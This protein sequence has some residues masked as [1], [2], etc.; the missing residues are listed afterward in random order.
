MDGR[1]L[2]GHEHNYD[3]YSVSVSDD[4]GNTWSVEEVR[5]KSRLVPE[6]RI[7]YAE[8]AAF[9]DP[10]REKLIVLIDQTLYPKDKLNADADYALVREVYDPRLLPLPSGDAL[11]LWSCTA[12][13]G[14]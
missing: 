9:F 7:R 13:G 6:G 8:P 14:C 4:N 11:N 12:N 1:C 5:W 2:S 3:D 10:D